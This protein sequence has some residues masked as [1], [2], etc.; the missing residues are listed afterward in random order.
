M[1][2]YQL[3]DCCMS[4]HKELPFTHVLQQQVYKQRNGLRC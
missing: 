1:I 3:D 2:M 4:L